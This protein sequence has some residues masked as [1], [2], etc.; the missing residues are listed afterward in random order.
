[1]PDTLAVRRFFFHLKMLVMVVIAFTV[2]TIT[3]AWGNELLDIVWEP[4][5]SDGPALDGECQLL[6]KR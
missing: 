1:M 5:C 3:S 2:L 4:P 6:E